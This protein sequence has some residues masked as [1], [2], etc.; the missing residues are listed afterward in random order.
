[1]VQAPRDD[2]AKDQDSHLIVPRR[3]KHQVPL[4]TRLFPKVGELNAEWDV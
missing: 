4:Q 1:M 3:L 2:N